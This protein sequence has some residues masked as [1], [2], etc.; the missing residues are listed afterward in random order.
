MVVFGKKRL[1][2]GKSGKNDCIRAKVVVLGQKL[3]Y[4]G[5]VDV[6]A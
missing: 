1:Y 6:F 5:N 4:S 3:L 2:L